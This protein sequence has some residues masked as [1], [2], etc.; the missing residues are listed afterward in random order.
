MR[1]DKLGRELD[2]LLLMIG[3]RSYTAAQLCEQLKI[4]RRNF[5]YYLDFFKESDFEVE[6]RGMIYSIDRHSPFFRKIRDVMDFNEEEVNYLFRLLRGAHKSSP[7][8]ERVLEKLSKFYDFRILNDVDFQEQIANNISNLYRAI[9]EKKV[10]KLKHYSSPHSR[11]TKDRLVEPYL[12]M[13]NEMDIRCYEIASGMNKT[14]KVT[15]MEDVEIEEVVWGNEDKHKD[16]YTDIFM[17]SGEEKHPV[18]LE[19]GQL[20]CNIFKEEYP[21]GSPF[22]QQID[23]QHW[24]LA[25]EVVSY[26]GIGRFVLG[27][28]EDIKV[29]EGDDFKAYL[30]EKIKGMEEKLSF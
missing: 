5:Y 18:K 2:L 14:F 22:L 19:L 30:R 29:V 16:V 6:K 3:N 9:K 28:F 24:L 8:K 1:H 7:I 12:F 4:S 11:S 25:L 13:N 17:F 26:A 15:R 27:L 20:A 21:Q 10:V 23:D